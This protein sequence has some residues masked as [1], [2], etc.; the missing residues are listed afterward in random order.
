MLNWLKFPESGTKVEEMFPI[1][2][3]LDDELTSLTNEDELVRVI[4]IQGRD[5][6]GMDVEKSE[7]LFQLRK[8]VFE[9]FGSEIVVSIHSLRHKLNREVESSSFDQEILSKISSA[10]SE[11]FT[12]TFRWR[13]CL[14]LRT[15]QE[16]FFDKLANRT[17]KTVKEN[18]INELNERLNDA[19][20]SV[21]QRLSEFKPRNLKG[22]ELKSYWATLLNGKYTYVVNDDMPLAE[23][24]A[25]IDLFWEEGA[26][27]QVYVDSPERYSAWLGIKAYPSETSAKML[28]A[29]YQLPI[30]FGVY[31][32]FSLL[33]KDKALRL[34]EE[35]GAVTANFK[36]NNAIVLIELNELGNRVEAEDIKL[37]YHS[38][39]VQ[40]FGQSIEELNRSVGIIRNAIESKGV[41]ALREKGLQEP[42]FWSMFPSLEHFNVRRR[43]VTTE[44]VARFV[45]FSNA[46]EGFE[47]CSFG[48]APVA[49]MKTKTKSIFSF[50]FH[51]SPEPMALGNTLVI[52]GSGTG[53]T[54]LVSF[55]LGMCHKYEGFKAMCFDRLHGMEIFTRMIG[56]SFN[57]FTSKAEINP[58][59]MPDRPENRAF[60]VNWLQLITNHHDDESMGQLSGIVSQSY[61][62]DLKSRNLNELTLAFGQKKKGNIREGI[63]KWL[64]NSTYGAFF[65]G[66]RDALSFEKS[67]ATFDMTL[68]L[69]M[70]DVLAAM[71]DYLFH[72]MKQTVLHE[73]APYAVF[74]DEFNKYIESPTFAPKML[75]SVSEMRKTNGVFIGAVQS[76]KT[77]LQTEIGR[78][79]QSSI[80]SYLLFPDPT[81]EEK[82]YMEDGLGL[83]RSEYEWIKTPSHREVMLKR[84]GGE[85]VILQTDL[86]SLGKYL[87]VFDSA[88]S[89]ISKLHKTMQL[90]PDNW[91]N[92]FLKR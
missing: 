26:D 19:C 74:V 11:Q 41:R 56:G 63:D 5:Y 61:L 92:D 33:D 21:M 83:N 75:E 1:V 14:V 45:S 2:R 3:V 73:P 28:D 9:M 38:W 68:L 36:K 91:K 51:A 4:D 29:L 81:G 42:L 15:A 87:H 32:T 37:G 17:N 55:L 39:A 50:T 54:T 57:D 13:H 18:S 35:R 44:N 82:Y 7:F 40:V 24:V 23:A 69:D 72:R 31:Q 86:S 6:T 67:L 46:G 66:E 90:S 71:A 34:I 53:K 78:Q 79:M 77:I 70:P 47:T 62:L 65:N 16:A 10:W 30:E 8:Q 88:S 25:G 85:S 58:F 48:A 49:L 43:A 89:S 12:T 80:A 76:A 59:Q 64:P 52:G 60:L 84:N 20:D 27:H 22:S